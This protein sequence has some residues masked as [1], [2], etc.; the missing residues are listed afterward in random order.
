VVE[1][2]P[3][4]GGIFL[5]RDAVR[6]IQ[7]PG[8]AVP[9]LAVGSTVGSVWSFPGA[10]ACGPALSRVVA[11]GSVATGSLA[12]LRSCVSTLA[13]RPCGDFQYLEPHR[14]SVALRQYFADW[15]DLLR[16]TAAAPPRSA[17]LAR[18]R[19]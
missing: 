18:V 5:Q 13:P 8:A 10:L 19:G 3:E 4:P 2:V 16:R 11:V 17:T 1:I 14:A 9:D 6:K 7:T 15:F 12:L